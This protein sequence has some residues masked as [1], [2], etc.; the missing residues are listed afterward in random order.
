MRKMVRIVIIALIL[1]ISIGTASAASF[2]NGGF[3]NPHVINPLG[4]DIYQDDTLFLVWD[5]QWVNDGT[6][7]ALKLQESQ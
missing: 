3:E 7:A 4:W 6:A 5:V 2:E 1:L